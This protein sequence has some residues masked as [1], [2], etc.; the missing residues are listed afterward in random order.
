MTSRTLNLQSARVNLTPP[1]DSFRLWAPSLLHNYKNWLC[2]AVVLQI[3]HTDWKHMLSSYNA[4]IELYL[5]IGGPSPSCCVRR[6]CDSGVCRQHRYNNTNTA[7]R[8]CY[9]PHVHSRIAG[10]TVCVALLLQS[11]TGVA[12]ASCTILAS[13]PVSTMRKDI[14]PCSWERFPLSLEHKDSWKMDGKWNS[15]FHCTVYR[16][17]KYN[18]S[19]AGDKNKAHQ[20]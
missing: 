20:H 16:K 12:A 7:S 3:V 13:T 8:S 19:F 6:S 15:W 2:G 4:C 9:A 5:K 1:S 18:T 14:Y 11:T 17:E 10:M